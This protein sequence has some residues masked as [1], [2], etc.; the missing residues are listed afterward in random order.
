MQG[1]SASR[2]WRLALFSAFTAAVFAC[3]CGSAASP[4]GGRD[5]TGDAGGAAV[6]TAVDVDP[7]GVPDAPADPPDVLAPVAPDV[8]TDA[9][10]YTLPENSVKTCGQFFECIH[11]CP[12]E[13]QSCVGACHDAMTERAA[14]L[15]RAFISCVNS[16][17]C[18]N[19]DCVMRNC[20]AQMGA[21]FNQPE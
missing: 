11:D 9:D 14:S 7:V 8:G 15:V 20:G 16:H 6:D 12:P 13:V 2:G 3:G 21:C 19:Q 1:R 17:S 5:A 18:Q 4:Q 10:A